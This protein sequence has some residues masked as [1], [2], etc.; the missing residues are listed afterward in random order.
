MAVLNYDE[1]NDSNN[2]YR[3][4]YPDSTG[5]TTWMWFPSTI[6]CP[7]CQGW[8][9]GTHIF[10]YCPYCGKELFPKPDKKAALLKRLDAILKEVKAIKE[11]LAK[12]G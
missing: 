7:H 10:H 9:Q 2:Y 4:F 11:E 3:D 5:T 6:S 8:I 1:Y 12:V